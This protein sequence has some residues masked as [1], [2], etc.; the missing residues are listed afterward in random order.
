MIFRVEKNNGYTVMSNHHL[1]NSNLTLKAKGLLSLMLSLPEEW[2][3]SLRGL[4][5]I[6]REGVDSIR[7]ALHELEAEG[8]II[9]RQTR[10]SSGQWDS[11]YII[12]ETPVKENST[13]QENPER[14]DTALENPTRCGT[15]LDF[16]IRQNRYGKT[17]PENPTE[18]NTDNQLLN[19]NNT[20]QSNQSNQ[21]ISK[22]TE[23]VADGMDGMDGGIHEQISYDS[24]MAENPEDADV[25]DGIVDIICQYS[26]LPDDGKPVY[27][28][29][30]A[31]K[32]AALKKRLSRLRKEHI[33]S[34]LAGIRQSNRPVKNYRAYLLA[35]LVNA[36]LSFTAAS[37]RTGSPGVKP[38][39]RNRFH[40][41]DQRDADYEDLK[42]DINAY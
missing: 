16:P 31:H 33:N 15:A 17:V 20:Y 3:Y 32:P 4:S 2:D 24:L 26:A 5:S 19:N 42:I 7:T 25:I 23:S 41:F 34:V 22:S 36:P 10:T 9:R 1:K 13:D 39:Q 35:A 6:C 28:N 12:Y 18:L 30:F 27:I 40:N 29:G 8:Y 38:G 21:S 11:E 14:T 37:V